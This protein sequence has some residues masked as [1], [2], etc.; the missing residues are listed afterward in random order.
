VPKT[1]KVEKYGEDTVVDFHPDDYVAKQE[2]FASKDGTKIPMFIIHRKDLPL[3]KD[4][5]AMLCVFSVPL[6]AVIVDLHLHSSAFNF[7]KM[8]L[9][10][11]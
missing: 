2:F 8:R 4:T 6:C 1:G 7:G 10:W 3:G 9:R 11:I 5:P